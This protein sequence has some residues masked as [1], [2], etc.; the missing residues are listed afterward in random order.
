MFDDR[1]A[2]DWL[3]T[4]IGLFP[5]SMANGRKFELD[6]GV[7]WAIGNCPCSRVIGKAIAELGLIT[8]WT[9]ALGSM[10]RS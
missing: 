9:P 8:L 3:Y 7:I 10:V 4:I 1:C 6:E 5:L 2:A